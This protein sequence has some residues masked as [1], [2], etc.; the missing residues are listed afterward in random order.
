MGLNSQSLHPHKVLHWLWL[1]T[2]ALVLPLSASAQSKSQEV[3]GCVYP[4]PENSAALIA[5]VA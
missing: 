2:L 3:D 5:E 4:M 1:V